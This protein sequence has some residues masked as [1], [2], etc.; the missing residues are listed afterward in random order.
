[1]DDAR[2]R[3]V[4]R[5]DKPE[6]RLEQSLVSTLPAVGLRDQGADL[7]LDDLRASHFAVGACML[8]LSHEN[9][10]LAD[11]RVTVTVAVDGFTVRAGELP[12]R[13]TTAPIEIDRGRDG[14]IWMC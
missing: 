1:V 13:D 5:A 6:C 9:R 2:P 10:Q 7:L 14:V 11:E 12:R 8:R 3:A 4:A